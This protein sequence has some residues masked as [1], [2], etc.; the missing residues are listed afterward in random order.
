VA[1]PR[2]KGRF[3]RREAERLL[4]RAGF[5]P[6]PGEADR[7][8]TK[9]LDG[10]VRSLTHPPTLRLEGPAPK[11]DRGHPLAPEDVVGHDHMWWFDRMVRSNQQLV[12][13]MTLVWH[14][15]FATAEA[16][17]DL[18]LDQNRLF[19][20]H[21]L[22]SFEELLLDVT[23]DPAMLLF[24]SGTENRKEEPNENYARE[25]MELFTLGA[26]ADYT[27]EDVREQA[28]ALT[29]WRN[30]WGAT[31]AINFRFDPNRHDDGI[32][33]IF[34]RR[35][36][37]DWRDSC[38][39]CLQHPKHPRY[40]VE[41]LWEAFVPTPPPAATRDALESLYLGSGYGIRPVVEAIL[42]HPALYEGPRMVKPPVVYI[43]GLLRGLE[44]GIESDGW[45][46]IAQECGQRLF[47][48][49]NVSGWDEDR[50]L[51]TATW[52]GRWRAANFAVRGREAAQDGYDPAEPADKAVLKAIRFWGEPTVTT[53]TRDELVA[54]ARQVDRLADDRWEEGVYR[55]RRQNALRMLVATSPDIQTS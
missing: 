3:G 54:F 51:D 38:R 19:R 32:K 10:A 16:E 30:D 26:G 18:L 15:W 42:K 53:T 23:V 44:R 9:G 28:R 52:R 17:T 45:T 12:E 40:F 34:G 29:G 24:L 21:A 43:A 39:L 4:W 8:A 48:P 31:G 27:E 50:W 33:T 2:Y 1:V 49:P 55:A 25:L 41:K 35:G 7:L 13:R 5:G 6:R 47:R 46:W 14:D 36:N 22:G 37:F 11:D 20:N